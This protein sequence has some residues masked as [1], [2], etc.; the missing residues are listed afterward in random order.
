MRGVRRHA[1]AREALQTLLVDRFDCTP[2]PVAGTSGDS[3][4]GDATFGGLL[5]ASS[6]P[7]TFGR[8]NGFEPV[9]VLSTA[10]WD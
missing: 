10:R 4:T 2:V 5:A 9:L 8:P 6:W 1:Q 3:F 7:T